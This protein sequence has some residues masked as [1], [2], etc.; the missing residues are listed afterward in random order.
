[1]QEENALRRKSVIQGPSF[2]LINGNNFIHSEIVDKNESSSSPSTDQS[3]MCV[4][5]KSYEASNV[6]F[7]A[8]DFYLNVP[9]PHCVLTPYLQEL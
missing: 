6:S 1:M 3:M 9:M 8:S 5:E 7:T 2:D 4:N